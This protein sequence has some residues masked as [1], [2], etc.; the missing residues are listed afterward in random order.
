MNAIKCILPLLLLALWGCDD[1]EPNKIT[2]DPYINDF[3]L[4]DY[5]YSTDSDPDDASVKLIDVEY[6][7]RAESKP[8]EEVVI[9]FYLLPSESS[10][11]STLSLDDHDEYELGDTDSKLLAQ[12]RHGDLNAGLNVLSD[13]FIIDDVTLLMGE[14]ELVPIIDPLGLHSDSTPEN[15]LP[16][17]IAHEEPIFGEDG[18]VTIG[19]DDHPIAKFEAENTKPINIDESDI[20]VKEVVLTGNEVEPIVIDYTRERDYD[21]LPYFPPHEIGYD[22]T[23]RNEFLPFINE[24]DRH[25]YVMRAYAMLNNEPKALQIWNEQEGDYCYSNPIYINDNGDHHIGFTTILKSEFDIEDGERLFDWITYYKSLISEDDLNNEVEDITVVMTLLPASEVTDDCDTI[26]W[27]YDNPDATTHTFTA[28]LFMNYVEKYNPETMGE[29]SAMANANASEVSSQGSE[30]D[31]FKVSKGFKVGSANK[32]KVALNNDVTL[33]YKSKL[34]KPDNIKYGV[35]ST[36]SLDATFFNQ[37]KPITNVDFNVGISGDDELK[38]ELEF[39]ILGL[40]PFVGSPANPINCDDTNCQNNDGFSPE[41]S[42]S[43]DI[44]KHEFFIGPVPLFVT[45]G[46]SG[47]LRLNF[48]FGFNPDYEVDFGAKE[49]VGALYL[50]GDLL[51]AELNSF[52]KGGLELKWIEAGPIIKLDLVNFKANVTGL[53]VPWPDN[54]TPYAAAVSSVDLSTLNGH[55]GLFADVTT[56]KWCSKKRWGVRFKYPCGKKERNYTYWVG[57][58][59]SP[60]NYENVE[61]FNTGKIHLF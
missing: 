31:F 53:L 45:F 42:D 59:K 23:Y 38:H 10:E 28:A 11:F 43:V 19:D 2:A 58:F 12:L 39:N 18:V 36:S 15:N 4:V 7:I 34:D 20:E 29:V 44:A 8:E 35:F 5:S 60:Y 14:Y 52:L 30:R 24:D 16:T 32:I 54:S 21:Y 33:S 3:E 25:L 27:E 40:K 56:L 26:D 13:Q 55:M 57:Q 37:T 46:A 17:H 49:S 51:V 6:T 48:E 61:I 47:T 1:D 41:W 22:F 9:E 50:G